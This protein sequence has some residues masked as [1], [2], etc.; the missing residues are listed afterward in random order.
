MKT[1]MFRGI[2]SLV[3]CACLLVAESVP[4]IACNLKSLTSEQ[5]KQLG[6]AGKHV[7][8]A[9]TTS[10]ELN[11]GYSFRVD[12]AKASLIDVA[13]WLDLWRRCCPFYEFRIDFHA[14]DASIW[15]SVE[16]RPGVKQ[17]IPID[18]PL[19]AAKLPK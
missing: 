11:D 12:P 2:A 10:R 7:I 18:A 6:E 14:A 15:L 8:S 16:G 13:Q 17:Y 3:G 5:R 4:P 1:K 9:I 19:L